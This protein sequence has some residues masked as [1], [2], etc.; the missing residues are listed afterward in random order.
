MIADRLQELGSKLIENMREDNMKPIFMDKDFLDRTVLNLITYNS[1][2]KLMV[3]DKV[4]ALL[5]ELWVGTLSYECDGR[6]NEFS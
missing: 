4:A 2:S 6:V 5:E 3:D 1:Y